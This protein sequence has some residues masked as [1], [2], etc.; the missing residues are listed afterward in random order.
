MGGWVGEEGKL[1]WK[2]MEEMVSISFQ[3]SLSPYLCLSLS[4][5]A[6]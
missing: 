4:L 2:L 3:V 6:P 5:S 1:P